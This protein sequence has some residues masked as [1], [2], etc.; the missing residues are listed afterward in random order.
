MQPAMNDIAYALKLDPNHKRSLQIA[1]LIDA[2]YRATQSGK[3]AT[4]PDGQN[5]QPKTSN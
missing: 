2:E 4:K 1:N 5:A 3:G